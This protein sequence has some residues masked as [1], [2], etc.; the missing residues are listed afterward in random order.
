MTNPLLL[1]VQ[2]LRSEWFWHFKMVKNNQK[3]NITW[4]MKITWKT[5]DSIHKKSFIGTQTYPCIDVLS[6][7]S[8]G[9]QWLG[10]VVAAETVWSTKPKILIAYPPLCTSSHSHNSLSTDPSCCRWRRNRGARKSLSPCPLHYF[11]YFCIVLILL[12]SLASSCAMWDH[13]SPTR[14]QTR[15]PCSG[16]FNHWTPRDV[17]VS[18]FESPFGWDFF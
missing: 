12:N 6:M 9:V 13:S 2:P 11:L 8:L 7:A 17:S 5:S 3:E 14:D 18:F 1:F 16:S 4:F 10:W 15:A